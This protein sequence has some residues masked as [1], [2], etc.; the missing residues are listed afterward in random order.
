VNRTRPSRRSGD[1]ARIGA[2]NRASHELRPH[3]A[4]SLLC[5]TLLVAF[6]LSACS[7]RSNAASGT[8]KARVTSTSSPKSRPTT[9]KRRSGPTTVRAQ[10]RTTTKKL[11]AT[12]QAPTTAV[13][14]QSKV[15]TVVPSSL[16][17]AARAR[18]PFEQFGEVRFVITDASGKDVE[19]CALLA[20]NPENQQRGLMGRRD[21]GGYDAML[22]T[23]NFDVQGGFWMRTVPVWLSI[24]WWDQHGRL[25]SSLDMAPCGDSAD[26]PVYTPTGPYRVAME[27]LRGGLEPLGVGPSAV[28]QVGGACRKT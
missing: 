28:L 12:T 23:W 3:G 9:A 25:V 1:R 26:C 6:G 24:A 19:Y 5:V 27:T 10:A 8:T 21:L 18:S 13:P 14:A 4:A 22:F 7:E 15:V 20:D 17:A 11:T 2:R 16:V